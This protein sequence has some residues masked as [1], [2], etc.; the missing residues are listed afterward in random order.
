MRPTP[1]RFP[2]R[3]MSVP[4]RGSSR[5]PFLPLTLVGSREL[6]VSGLLDTGSSVNVLPLDTGVGLG[7][8]W[9]GIDTTVR[10][11]GNLSNIEAKVLLVTAK[12]MHF[13]PMRLAFAWVKSN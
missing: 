6:E 3:E 7:A 2:Y 9:E 11:T 12:F 10:L 4:A 8:D 13:P 5:L 1:V